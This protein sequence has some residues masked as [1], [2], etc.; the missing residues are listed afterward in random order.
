MAG[1]SEELQQIVDEGQKRVAKYKA[2]WPNATHEENLAYSAQIALGNNE[3]ES[4][5]INAAGPAIAPYV[6]ADVV[7][8]IGFT[9]HGNYNLKGFY[10]TPDFQ[11]DTLGNIF[12]QAIELSTTPNLVVEAD[13]VYSVGAGANPSS[14]THEFVHRRNAH[15]MAEGKFSPLMGEH[16]WTRMFTA[17]RAR[18]PREWRD[19]VESYAYGMRG[20]PTLEEADASLRRLLDGYE[21]DLIRMEVEALEAQNKRPLGRKWAIDSHRKDVKEALKRRKRGWSLT[22]PGEG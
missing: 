2:P 13:K 16:K 11:S 9:G 3:F 1:L 19:A 18:N 21:D 22:E 14:L 17:F 8:H 7:D 6:D 5:I 12:K 10:T 4:E 15:K 20:T